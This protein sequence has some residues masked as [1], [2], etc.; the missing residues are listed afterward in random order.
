[1][2]R[3]EVG[4]GMLA[5]KVIAGLEVLALCFRNSVRIFGIKLDFGCFLWNILA[6]GTK[7]PAP[8]PN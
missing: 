8:L 4:N 7:L 5:W 1:M 6:G 3:R 2:G